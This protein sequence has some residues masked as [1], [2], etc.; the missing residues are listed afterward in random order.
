MAMLKKVAITFCAKFL[1]AAELL[2][3]A[4]KMKRI[5]FLIL[6]LNSL[7]AIIDVPAHWPRYNPNLSP[8]DMYDEA[9]CVLRRRSVATPHAHIELGQYFSSLYNR[10]LNESA[11]AGYEYAIEWR[12][13]R[14]FTDVV[15][16]RQTISANQIISLEQQ[17]EKHVRNQTIIASCQSFLSQMRES[18]RV[19]E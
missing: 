7:M 19:T 10:Y 4:V 16:L 5:L 11:D 8:E 9:G 14:A 3:K 2:Q 17:L 12:I 18:K 13:N 1:K 15:A 6:S